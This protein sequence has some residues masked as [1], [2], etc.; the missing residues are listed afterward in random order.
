MI[1]DLEMSQLADL[2]KSAVAV[3][4]AGDKAAASGDVAQAQRYFMSVKQCG[5][6]LNSTNCLDLVRL[7]GKS[8]EKKAS[9]ELAKIGS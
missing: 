4:Q 3:L 9:V 7:V 2:K 6:A 1:S 8:F 5:E